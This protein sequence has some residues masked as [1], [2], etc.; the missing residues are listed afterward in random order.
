[1]E[2]V[3]YF[4]AKKCKL[5]AHFQRRFIGQALWESDQM[6]RS[7]TWDETLLNQTIPEH[8]LIPAWDP[9][10]V[11]WCWYLCWLIF[12]LQTKLRLALNEL[13][14]N[15][16][17]IQI[18]SGTLFG[19]NTTASS[20]KYCPTCLDRDLLMNLF[21]HKHTVWWLWTD[22]YQLNSHPD[23]ADSSQWWVF[24]W[25]V[26]GWWMITICKHLSNANGNDDEQTWRW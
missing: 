10:M 25:G 26:G 5:V 4:L 1:M 7:P 8:T 3:G 23:S 12:I 9:P 16:S 24:C 20:R 14:I 15:C 13:R 17:H 18:Q 6:H 22:A 11:S 2:K 19:D 21:W